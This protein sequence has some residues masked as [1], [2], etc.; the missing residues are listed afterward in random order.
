MRILCLMF[1][2]NPGPNCEIAPVGIYCLL[3]CVIMVL[4]SFMAVS[5]LVYLLMLKSARVL[6]IC[7]VKF[8]QS[9]RL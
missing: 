8:S 5:M 2:L 9:A 7:C 1:L 6:S 3:F 4:K